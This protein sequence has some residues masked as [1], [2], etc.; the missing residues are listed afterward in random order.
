MLFLLVD[1]SRLACVSSFADDPEL[2][3]VAGRY[4]PAVPRLLAQSEPVLAARPDLIVAAPWNSRRFLDL[5]SALE[6][7]SYVLDEGTDFQQIRAQLVALGGR[8]G[9]EARAAEAAAAMDRRLD[10]LDRRLEGVTAR[11]SVLAVSH[12]VVAGGGTTVDALIRRAG[13]RNLAAE[14]GITGHRKVTAERL[15]ALDPD[16]LLLG[17]DSGETAEA[18]LAE[19]PALGALRAAR[20]GRIIEL[21]PRLLTTVTPFLVDGAEALAR[22][23]HPEAFDAGGTKAPAGS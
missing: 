11:P 15:V 10:A 12:L 9:A 4:P 22:G 5:L 21:P 19:V 8:I 3:N 18:L 14:K 17:L 16:V 6:V 2:S 1:P 13:G 23:L 20:E 7:P